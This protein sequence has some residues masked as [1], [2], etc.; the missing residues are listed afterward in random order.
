MFLIHRSVQQ[1]KNEK[2]AKKLILTLQKII[3]RRKKP[4][5][6]QIVLSMH[7]QILKLGS[8][9]LHIKPIKTYHRNN[10]QNNDLYHL[11]LEV[12][13]RKLFKDIE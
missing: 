9:F 10:K 7:E 5:I 4:Y 6:K 13:K 8:L 2:T 1:L 3:F 11:Q 12:G